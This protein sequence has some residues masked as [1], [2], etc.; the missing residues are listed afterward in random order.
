[1][2]DLFPVQVHA[3]LEV[4]RIDTR[5]DPWPQGAEG[6]EG[7]R[8]GPL[9]VPGLQIPGRDIVGAGI[10]QDTVHRLPGFHG[11][12]LSS[13]YDGELGFVVH[14][15]RH[16]CGIHHGVA[17]GNDRC[18]RLQEEQ[19][20]LRY[21]KA[22]LD[23]VVPVVESHRCYLGRLHGR[24]EPFR[25]V[26]RA[27]G[28]APCIFAEHIP[29]QPVDDAVL[30]Q[31]CLPFSLYDAPHEHSFH[32]SLLRRAFHGFSGSTTETILP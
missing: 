6:V 17:V 16:V 24:K 32:Y 1:M 23:G 22:D 18:G 21:G 13:Y 2:L 20:F 26:H 8:P 31:P 29:L 25:L 14:P 11:R 5:D 28:G 15:L 27:E 12:T 9:A 3:D 7:L 30:H 10:A 4:R 19:G